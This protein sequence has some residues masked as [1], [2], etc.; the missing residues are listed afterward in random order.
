MTTQVCEFC[1][2]EYIVTDKRC[3]SYCSA[4]CAA[5]AKWADPTYKEKMRIIMSLSSNVQLGRSKISAAAK[6][7][8]NR[9]EVKIARAKRITEY[10][11]KPG[12][13]ELQS[14]RSKARWSDPEYK[15]NMII[16]LA[17]YNKSAESRLLK[18]KRM[19]EYRRKDDVKIASSIWV[20]KYR[21]QPGVKEKY[22]SM[23]KEYRAKPGIKEK[24][25]A[26]AKKHA[27]LPEVKLFKSLMMKSKWD[28]PEYAEKCFKSSVRRKEYI[29]PSGRKVYVQGYE[30]L[31]L[32][33][34]I[35]QYEE[36]DIFVGVKEIFN[37]IGRITY[38]TEDNIEHNYYPDI[39]IKSTNTIIEV[40]SKWTY[41][42]DQL[43]NLLKE[44]ACLDKGFK[45]EFRIL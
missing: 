33:D 38:Q 21:S 28:D 19:I 2:I 5:K 29:F 30:N 43:K 44:R 9:P 16:K 14:I 40:K 26:D 24:Y 27:Q 6:E 35:N 20:K 22:S 15:K 32:D 34:L 31:A 4:S 37:Q 7:Y 18:S 42:I 17:N 23:M 36:N 39:F 11:N 3:K 45:F 10:N 41:N 13:K 12:V 1:K 8:G 25:S